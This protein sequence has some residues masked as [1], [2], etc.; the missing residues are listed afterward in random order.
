MH[1]H[2]VHIKVFLRVC[3]TNSANSVAA[4]RVYDTR[5]KIV[6]NILSVSK[7][8]RHQRLADL[9]KIMNRMNTIQSMSIIK[10]KLKYLSHIMVCRKKIAI[11]ISFNKDI[12]NNSRRCRKASPG[13]KKI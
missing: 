11:E 3:D 5:G 9:L 8:D 4:L 1:I 6:L 2:D 7:L 12:E 10:Y 13:S